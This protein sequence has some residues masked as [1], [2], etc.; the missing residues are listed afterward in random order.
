MSFAVATQAGRSS[1]PRSQPGLKP[2]GRLPGL[3]GLRAI[4]FC[5]VL[6]AHLG[7][8]NKKPGGFAVDVFFALS[9]YLIT[10]LLL[11]EF[12][13][14]GDISLSDFYLRRT[15][16]I[17][18][19][20]YVSLALCMLLTWLHVLPGVLRST[21]IFAEF[22]YLQNCRTWYTL[23]L[24]Q[25]GCVPGTISYW[26]L[27][28]EEHF[29]LLF[30]LALLFMLRRRVSWA[31]MVGILV[32]VCFAF[33]VWRCIAVRV[34]FQGEQ[35]CDRT[36]DARRDSIL[37]GCILS[38]LQQMAP[39]RSWL[40]GGRRLAALTLLGLAVIVCTFVYHVVG[41]ETFR[42]TIQAICLLPM[43]Y[44]VT[45]RPTSWPGRLLEHP[46]LVHL[47]GL[48]Y[49]LYLVHEIAIEVVARYSPAQSRLVLWP[50]SAFTAYLLA[51]ALHW[52]V[53]RPFHGLR[54]RFRP[55]PASLPSTP[56]SHAR[57][58]SPFESRDTVPSA[59]ITQTS[60]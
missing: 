22:F 2:G 1:T 27:C 44:Y 48:S 31:K 4:S 60:G 26:S 35:Y 21:D 42:F 12:A 7:F 11:R 56:G 20:M 30:P 6:L 18:P 23:H 25:L 39:V 58:P 28:V 54:A 15:L 17:F 9:G 51:A 5:I 40:A 33:L 16:R 50:L 34:L 43:L 8:M 29:Y 32:L 49:S 41:H 19:A 57:E 10:T 24:G 52:G 45:H 37:W 47:G 3:D 36:S 55:R 53:E 13:S 46:V 38:L 14:T 59:A